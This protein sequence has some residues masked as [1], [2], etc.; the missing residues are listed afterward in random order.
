M[1]PPL[2]AAHTRVSCFS[3][4]FVSLLSSVSRVLSAVLAEHA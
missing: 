4:A 2:Q 1:W 3:C